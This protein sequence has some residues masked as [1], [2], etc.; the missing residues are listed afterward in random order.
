MS[1]FRV[2]E[3]QLGLGEEFSYGLCSHCGSLQLLDAVEDYAPYYPNQAYYSFNLETRKAKKTDAVRRIQADYLLYGKSP[4]LG[5]LLTLGYKK[6]EFYSWLKPTGV[7]HHD[8]ILDVGCG[9][10]SLLQQLR[11]IGFTRLT[12]IDP[13]I[14]EDRNLDGLHILK[15]DIHALQEPYDLIMM[16]HSL[17]HMFRPLEAL[18]KA[19]S[20]LRPG[21]YLLVR[22]PVM[23]NYGWH[24]F[25]TFW[26]GID[27]PR[28]IFIPSE[29]GFC[30]LAEAAGF[31]V[32]KVAYDSSDYVIW[33]SEQ[34]KKNIPLHAPNS[35]MVSRDNSTF[36]K[37]E[38]RE[39][40][41][42]IAAE[43]ARNNG[44]TAAFYLKKD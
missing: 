42:T 32:E 31:R 12:G 3:L 23:G 29:K 4:L 22:L 38:I 20:L 18:K 14:D 17:E 8:A 44:D 36:S 16:H 26:C 10:G 41:K 39:F 43:N 35:R 40:K 24:R 5:G 21:R 30:L 27:A 15:K 28:H 11:T 13:F 2:K 19:H 1:T 6:P 33:S 34:Y 9:N 25:G 37:E 7:R